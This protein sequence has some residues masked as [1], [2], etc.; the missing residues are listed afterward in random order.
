MKDDVNAKIAKVK[1]VREGSDVAAIT[2]AVNDLSTALQK[3]GEALY[4][5]KDDTG[6][7]SN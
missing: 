1:E 7:S 4:N 3:I 6:P 5:K 2:A